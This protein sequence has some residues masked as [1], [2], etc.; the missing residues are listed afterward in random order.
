MCS[1][2]HFARSPHSTVHPHA[3]GVVHNGNQRRWPKGA[4]FG[5]SRS[6]PGSARRASSQTLA[7]STQ[8][9]PCFCRQEHAQDS[10]RA[11]AGSHPARAHF[12][13]QPASRTTCSCAI[14]PPSWP[15]ASSTCTPT[16]ARTTACSCA[17]RSSSVSPRSRRTF[18][19]EDFALRHVAQL[20][21]P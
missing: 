2:G 20:A 15:S 6:S 12:Y 7:Q 21:A 19:L 18:W 16:T 14:P 9:P 8:A 4:C 11:P 10:P 5:P 17:P 13:C 3:W 1:F